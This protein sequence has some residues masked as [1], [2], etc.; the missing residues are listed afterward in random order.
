MAP[1]GTAEL[2]I[3]ACMR[4]MAERG[5][6]YATLG[7]VA[8]A[9]HARPWTGHNPL[10][11]RALF[12]WARAHGRRFYNFEGLEFFREKMRPA[13]WEGVYAVAN[14]RPFPPGALWAIATAFCDGSPVRALAASLGKAVRQEWRWVRG[15]VARRNAAAHPAAST[16]GGS[17]RTCREERAE[18]SIA[19]HAKVERQPDE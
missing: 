17:A 7:L 19:P 4:R 1:N 10:W 16:R 15:A 11:L 14:C 6:G 9:R 2:L 13:A 5:A 8:L 12:G 18:R 3:D